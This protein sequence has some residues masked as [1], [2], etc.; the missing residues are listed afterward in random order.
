VKPLT[1]L[2]AAVWLLMA[3]CM[4]GLLYIAWLL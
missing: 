1:M 4:I 2:L 3:A